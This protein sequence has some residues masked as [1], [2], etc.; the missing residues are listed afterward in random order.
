MPSQDQLTDQ[1]IRSASA[2]AEELA[3]HDALSNA[4][5]YAAECLLKNA[6]WQTDVA[7]VLDRLGTASRVSRVYVFENHTDLSGRVLTSQRHEWAAEGVEPQIDNPDLQSMSLVEIGF[8]RWHR[9][10]AAGE[11]VEGPVSG[12]PEAERPFLEAQDIRSLAVVP[13]FTNDEWWGFMGFDD[14]VEERVW[15]ESSLAVLGTAADLFGA[16]VS[17]LHAEETHRRLQ[18][19]RTARREAQAAK[20]RAAFLAEAT[21]IL[22]SSFDYD[23]TLARFARMSVPF[24]GDYC[25]VD[26]LDGGAMR[27]VATAHADPAKEHLVRELQRFPPKWGTNPIVRALRSGRSV[28]STPDE[29]TPQAISGEP[30]HQSLLRELGPRHGV[31]AP[32]RSTGEVLGVM[33]F[34]SCDAEREYGPEE[35]TFAEDLAMRAGMAIGNAQLFQTA[36][37]ASRTRDEVLAMVAHDLRNP[38]GSILG[39]SRMIEEL[40]DDPTMLRFTAIIGRSANRMNQLIEDLLDASRM[41]RGTLTLNSVPVPLKAIISEA[42]TMLQPLAQGQAVELR[43]TPPDPDVQVHADPGRLLQVLSNLIGNA[44][45]FTPEGGRVELR[46]GSDADSAL[47]QVEDT[48]PGIPPDQIPRLF[49][50]YWQASTADRRGVGL[51][52]SIARGIIEAHGGR[53]WVESEPGRG[54]TFSVVLPLAEAADEQRSREPIEAV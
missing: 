54:S 49:N 17:R 27:R 24:L 25:I 23:T 4:V 38:L 53:I 51:G 13:I 48:G 12:F 15:G 42:C 26:V 22:T 6:D 10:L 36:Q 18:K 30:E 5:L 11:I 32:I 50:R 40:T 1:L 20:E 29:L 52:L 21:S 28:M 41:E 35:L 3:R 31:F 46:A 45:K 43:I 16:A 9:L 44:L 2:A 39:G 19:E 7:D 34:C 14:C 33:T 8:E 37:Q 47:I